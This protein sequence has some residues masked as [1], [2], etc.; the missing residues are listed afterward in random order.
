MKY[1]KQF[2]YVCRS[3]LLFEFWK[4]VDKKMTMDDYNKFSKISCGRAL[5]SHL[6]EVR[7]IYS[8]EKKKPHFAVVQ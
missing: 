2:I 4:P 6:A 1:S 8:L 3:L 7:N 5:V